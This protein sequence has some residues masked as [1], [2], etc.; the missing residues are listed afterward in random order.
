MKLAQF[1]NSCAKTTESISKILIMKNRLCFVMAALAITLAVS[2]CKPKTMT[3]AVSGDAAAKA[4][5]APGQYDQF[6]NFVS[7]GFS[8]QLS[9]YGLPSGRLLRV[10]PVFSVDPEKGWG[11]SEETKPMLN[12]S[13]GFVPWD[14][15]HH[16][17]LS[18]T[19]GEVDE[20]G[21]ASCRERV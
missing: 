3:T 17:E 20:I 10:I 8:G 12:T 4:Y 7:G 14:D 19:N 13:H 15:L 16:T 5:V 18:Q 9:T 6:Y 2:S 21:R 11:Y 1:W